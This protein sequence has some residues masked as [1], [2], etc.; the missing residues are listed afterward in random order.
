MCIYRQCCDLYCTM[1]VEDSVSDM[2]CLLCT[3]CSGESRVC[4]VSWVQPTP[5]RASRRCTKPS[6]VMLKPRLH[7]TTCCQT[8]LTTGWMFVYTIQPV[9]SCIQTLNCCQPIWQPAV[10]CKQTSKW[11]SNR[12]DNLLD[13]CLVVKPVWQL[14][15]LCKRGMSWQ[16]CFAF[17]Q[18][19]SV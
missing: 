8:G 6:S 3:T 10:S 13:V 2:S 17:F 19:T 12:V 11:L 7:D 9:V 4:W 5:P 16:Y 14:V 1:F 18:T 15:V